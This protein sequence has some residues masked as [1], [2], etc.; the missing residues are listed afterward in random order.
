MTKRVGPS[1]LVRSFCRSILHRLFG[2]PR[3][4]EEA[5]ISRR[6]TRRERSGT[7]Q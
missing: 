3:S 6:A 4:Y 1:T 5:D 7:F 2:I